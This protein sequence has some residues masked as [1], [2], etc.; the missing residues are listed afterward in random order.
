MALIL[1]TGT[2]IPNANAYASVAFVT[3]YLTDLGRQTE[4]SW[5]SSSVPQQEAAIVAATSYIDTRW[6]G[7]FLGNKSTF[8]EGVAARALLT[9]TGTPAPAETLT[10]SSKTYTYVGLLDD[11]NVDEILIGADV[12]E[13]IENTTAVINSDFEIIASLRTGTNNQILLS[14]EVV[15]VSGNDTPLATTSAGI[16]VT[17][18]FQHG[19]DGGSQPLEFPRTGLFDSSGYIVEGV[20]LNVKQA[21]AEY[22]V[23]AR[24]SSL[25]ADPTFDDRGRVVQRIMERVGPIETETEYA[26]GAAL[27]QLIRPY[28]AADRLLSQ[29]LRPAGVTR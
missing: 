26:D 10:V 13:T 22:A 14:Q 18:S 8:I 9:V 23:R 6:S 28:P 15:G 17:Q 27:E 24:G 11:F 21:T 4:N 1:E 25:F 3:G 19:S 7:R 29:Y 20:P 5:D 16:T 2:G 12:S